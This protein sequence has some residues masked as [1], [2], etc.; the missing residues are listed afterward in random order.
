MQS[1]DCGKFTSKYYQNIYF[2]H[3][4]STYETLPSNHS[5]LARSIMF[6]V[7]MQQSTHI[8]IPISL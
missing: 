6:C 2:T 7:R 8:T 1:L 3:N 5:Y 4:A